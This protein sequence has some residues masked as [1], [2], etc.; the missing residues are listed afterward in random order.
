MLFVVKVLVVLSH[1]FI[2]WIDWIPPDI[3]GFCKWVFDSLEVLSGS[4]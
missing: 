4:P 2:L 3:H 1:L